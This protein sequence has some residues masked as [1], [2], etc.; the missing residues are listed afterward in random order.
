[1]MNRPQRKLYGYRQMVFPFKLRHWLYL[2]KVVILRD[3]PDCFADTRSIFVHVPKAAGLSIG[4]SLYGT[5][6][7]HTPAWVH[8]KILGP[9]YANFFKFTISRDPIDRFVSSYEFLKSGGLSR[10]P[11]DRAFKD[12]VIDQ[13]SS[14]DEFV[15][16]WLSPKSIHTYIHFFPQHYFVYDQNDQCLVDYVGKVETLEQEFRLICEQLNRTCDLQH[17]NSAKKKAKPA[18]AEDSIAKIRETYA[19]DFDLFGY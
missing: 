11:L 17:I 19:K 13:F 14:I 1:M 6:V 10:H 9:D 3:I 8:K 16:N 2:Q 15:A 7:G 5:E 18:L 12:E 4:A